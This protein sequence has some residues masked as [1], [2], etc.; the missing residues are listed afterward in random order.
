[1]L[2]AAGVDLTNHLTWIIPTAAL[3]TGGLGG[4]LLT[5]F[6]SSFRSRLQPVSYVL[7]TQK[8]FGD[9]R[10]NGELRLSVVARGAVNAMADPEHF[11]HLYLVQLDIINVGNRDLEEFS[12]GITFNDS[13]RILFSQ[14]FAK[15]RHHAIIGAPTPSITIPL[16]QIDFKCRPFNRRDSYSVTLYAAPALGQTDIS[17]PILSTSQSVRLTREP[18]L[19]EQIIKTTTGIIRNYLEPIGHY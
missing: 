17:E 18:G 15:D 10:P 11:D 7:S 6:V 4:A 9:H 19:S 8:L 1:M 2:F 12:F 13:D 5:T 14:C 16:S 3:F